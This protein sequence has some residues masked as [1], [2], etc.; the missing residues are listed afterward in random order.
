MKNLRRLITI[1]CLFLIYVYSVNISNFPNNLI[2]YNNSS[3]DLKLCPFLNLD[4]EIQTSSTN[5]YKVYNMNIK[6]GDIPLKQVNFKITDDIDVIPCGNLV[7]LKLYSDGVMIV[8]FSKLEDISG[9]IVSLEDANNLKAG[10]RII[11][12][13]DETI[14][15]IEDLKRKVNDSSQNKLKI[16]AIDTLG[17]EKTV[18]VKPIHTG[19]NEYKLGLWVKDA[20][21][22]VGTLSFYIPQ[23]EQFVALGHGISDNDTEELINIDY[24]EITSTSIVSINK[25]EK[26]MPRRS[27]RNNYR[28]KLWKDIA[29]Y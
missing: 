18:N 9:N 25:G 1:F 26:G 27:K 11:R 28:Y 16:D 13:N 17:N 21:T 19:S 3:I 14:K 29:K 15:T 8:G 22:G 4:G 23:T 6:L 20:A 2:L 12:V 5:N 7:G 10:D 24:G